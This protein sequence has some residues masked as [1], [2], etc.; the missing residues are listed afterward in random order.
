MRRYVGFTSETSCL[1]TA[2]VAGRM[3]ESNAMNRRHVIV[4]GVVA[5]VLLALAVANT[6]HA[7]WMGSSVRA[8]EQRGPLSDAE[9]ANIEIFEKVSPSVVQVAAQSAANPLSEETE[10]GAASG[11]GFIWDN[12]GHVVTNNHVVQ[13]ASE[14]AVRF[15]SGEVARAEIVGTAA[16]YD[17]AVLRIRSARTLPPPVAIGNSAE[18]KVGQSAFAIGNPFGL[19]Q[20]MTSGIISAL[21]RRLPT[22]TGREIANVIQT[23]TAINPG[24]SGGP[25][26]DSAGRLIGVTT[27]ILSPSGS[28]TGIGFAVPVDIVNRVVPDLIRNGRVPTPG[29]GIVAASEAVATRLGTEGVIVVRT[30]PG[31][32]AERAGIRGVDLSSGGLGD[33]ITAADGKPVRRLSDLTDQLEQIGAGKTVRLSIKRGSQT[34]DVEVAIVDID[35]TL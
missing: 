17:L 18:L 5:A 8:V 33:V 24:N 4:L 11:T 14:V 19:D 23:D 31:S 10:G 3:P 12:D 30:T 15:A 29:I 26:L 1:I 2:F 9:R 6:R 7:P 22:S 21:K 34:R 35:R 32:P 25:L 28:N 16:N 27:A 20:S 13:N